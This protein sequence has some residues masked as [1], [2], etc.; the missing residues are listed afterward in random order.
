MDQ[1]KSRANPEVET[2]HPYEGHWVNS[3]FVITRLL[4]RRDLVD[5]NI[6]P[7]FI[8]YFDNGE[9]VLVGW[10]DKQKQ[11]LFYVKELTPAPGTATDRRYTL[12]V[13]R[14]RGTIWKRLIKAVKR[15]MVKWFQTEEFG[16]FSKFA[17]PLVKKIYPSL[18]A[19]DLVS[20]Q[21][22]SQPSSVI[23]YLNKMYG[24]PS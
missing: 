19:N 15:G 6:K 12:K 4:N 13:I 17:F 23:F 18:I 1:V 9:R 7:S 8:V 20:V 5:P 16:D 2:I 21:P 24:K 11:R 10:T 14:M 22:M 3:E